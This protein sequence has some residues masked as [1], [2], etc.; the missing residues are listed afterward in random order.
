MRLRLFICTLLLTA[1]IASPQTPP[2][3]S[4]QPKN[5]QNTSNE[6]SL[7]GRLDAN[8]HDEEAHK[9]LCALLE[10]RGDIRALVKERWA[11]LDDNPGD[12]FELAQLMVEAE[13]RLYDPEYA[14]TAAKRYLSNP[15]LT[16]EDIAGANGDLARLL[17]KRGRTAE[18][19]SYFEATTKAKPDIAEFWADLGDALVRIGR[20]DAGIEALRKAIDLDSSFSRFH[21]QLGDA[22]AV[23]GNL[24]GQETEY[25]AA[26][27]LNKNDPL[28]ANQRASHFVTLAKLQIS[29]TEFKEAEASLDEAL[30]LDPNGLYAYIVRAQ[31][32]EKEGQIPQAQAQRKK[33]ESAVAELMKKEKK[34]SFVPS[35]PLAI[36]VENDPQETV[37]ILETSKEH[38]T[39]IERM[40]LALAYF[41]LGRRDEGLAQLDK[42]F[43]DPKLITA[44]AHFTFA[45]ALKKAR[46]NQEAEQQYRKAYEMD[47]ENTTYRYEYEALGRANTSQS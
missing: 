14:I 8:P 44:Q 36:F 24:A 46:L 18:A 43:E 45:E 27:S 33:A 42:F 37:R 34:S 10:G 12:W 13:I 29:R 17:V 21:V 16:P 1:V 35:Q 25:K 30:R 31:L 47:P 41:D 2:K 40:M 19:I 20:I 22:L 39:S 6:W 3:K 32:L 15:N 9:K 38:L 11:W 7:R 23:K 4:T 28:L 26:C 5:L